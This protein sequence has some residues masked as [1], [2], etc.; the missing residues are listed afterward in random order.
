[1]HDRYQLG[2]WGND[3]YVDKYD[4][5]ALDCSYGK[6]SDNDVTAWYTNPKSVSDFDNR[7]A[8]VLEHSNPLIKGA[9]KWKDL[10]EHIF[11][12]NIQNEGQGHL[13]KNTAPVPE[14]WCDRAKS[15]RKIM[16]HSDVLI[17]T[18]ESLSTMSEAPS[19]TD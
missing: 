8:H 4:L 6:A 5:P 16:G 13:D 18:G 17:S 1:L 15:M 2:C 3:S 14:W 11:S 7:I 9:P 10:S 12:F 19:S